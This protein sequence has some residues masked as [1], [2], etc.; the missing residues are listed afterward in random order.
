MDALLHSRKNWTKAQCQPRP[1][2][3]S[4]FSGKAPPRR[5]AMAAGFRESR[6][7][8]NRCQVA[9]RSLKHPN[10]GSP[11]RN[12]P[13]RTF[14]SEVTTSSRATVGPLGGVDRPPEG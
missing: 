10:M 4:D 9:C 13:C 5:K 8:Q 11:P 12:A 1:C 2:E 14:K 7:S 6:V 3:R